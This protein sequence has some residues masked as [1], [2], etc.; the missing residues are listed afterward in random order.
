MWT[1]VRGRDKMTRKGGREASQ[2]REIEGGKKEPVMLQ[3]A[4]S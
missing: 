2:R 1:L 3:L 4:I